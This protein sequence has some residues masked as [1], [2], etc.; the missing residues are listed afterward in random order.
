MCT[1]LSY[2]DEISNP[3]LTLK[4]SLFIHTFPHEIG[5]IDLE[6][7]LFARMRHVKDMLCSDI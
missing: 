4:I 5:Q 3:F 1:Y 7:F 2:L 6:G